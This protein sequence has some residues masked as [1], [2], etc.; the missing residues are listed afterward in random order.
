MR[1]LNN[2]LDSSNSHDGLPY[3]AREIGL[4]CCRASKSVRI[5]FKLW[6]TR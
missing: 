1:N 3:A 2:R 4:R 5:A 6:I